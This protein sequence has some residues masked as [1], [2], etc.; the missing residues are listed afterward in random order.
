MGIKNKKIGIWGFGKV[1]KSIIRYFIDKSI[2]CEDIKLEILDQRKLTDQ[3][4]EFLEKNNIKY[5]HYTHTSDTIAAFLEHNDII[6][7]SPGIDI[8]PYEKNYKKHKHKFISEL[9]LFQ[10]EI[11]KIT[12]KMPVIGVTGSVGK[13]TIVSLL[14]QI[15]K[16]QDVN[17]WTGGNIGTPLLDIFIDTSPKK[18]TPELALFELSSFQLENSKNFAPDLAIWTN[19]YPNH[20][21][22]HCDMESYFLAKAN[23]IANQ[24][25]ALLPFNIIKE[26]KAHNILSN[27][28]NTC[29]TGNTG[30]LYFF[31]E[32]KPTQKELQIL[33]PETVLFYLDSNSVKSIK[34]VQVKNTSYGS[35]LD[36]SEVVSTIGNVGQWGEWA[37][38][39]FRENLLILFSSMY[40][41]GLKVYKRKVLSDLVFSQKININE[42]YNKHLAHRL[43]KIATIEGVTFYNDSKATTGASTLAAIKKLHSEKDNNS[44]IILLLGGLSKG[45]D[46]AP[47]IKEIK[48]YTKQIISFGKEAQILR[49]MCQKE[50]VGCKSFDTL[51]K[52]IKAAFAQATKGD[53]ILLS[54]AGSSFDLFQDYQA[55]GERFKEIVLQI[56]KSK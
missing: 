38:F 29:N 33:D 30:K 21:D 43:E 52:T 13:T 23:I 10:E 18:N 3:E 40:I 54:P 39:T 47:L 41:L 4:L 11:N 7:P 26:L 19:F 53:I 14:D 34:I 9:Y 28:S 5:T 25:C 56:P 12:P 20:L 55:R 48:D 44:N 49:N 35:G 51:E 2:N 37:Q 1:G 42:T 45:V 15:L 16:L 8:N 22:R 32:H 17:V 46:R 24:S 27:T 50:E 6:V 36:T 31:S